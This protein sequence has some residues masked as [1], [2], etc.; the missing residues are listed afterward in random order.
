MLI[1]NE[2]L[3]KTELK[4]LAILLIFQLIFVTTHSQSIGIQFQHNSNWKAILTKAKDENKYILVDCY[5]TWCGP[6]KQMD[7]TVFPLEN[8]G[9]FF[10]E[11]FISVKI[12][13]DSTKNDVEEIKAQ[14]ADAAFIKKEYKITGY[15]T[16]LFFNP[17]G[18]LVHEEGG[19]CSP[20]EFITRGNNA[21]NVESQYYTQ[22]K[23]YNAGD[24]DADFL[25]RLTKLA[26][27]AHNENAISKYAKAYYETQQDLLSSDNLQFVYE[28]TLNANDTG[29]HLM[30]NNLKIFETAVEPK[31]LQTTLKF[32]I[33]RSE[34]RLNNNIGYEWDKKKWDSF[35]NSLLIKYPLF[36]KE[37]LLQFEILVFPGQNNWK[38]YAEAV[39]KYITIQT[40]SNTELNEY[41]WTIFG[42]CNKKAILEKALKWSKMSFT[43]KEKIDPGYIDTYANILYKMG[44]KNEALKWEKKAQKI[45]IEQGL[46]KNW[47]QDVI[48]KINKGE[49]TW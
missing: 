18:E 31:R 17:T 22:I 48:D 33:I 43:N 44:E 14:Y 19:S 40:P 23:K 49:Q 47:G 37:V 20:D 25:K 16:F 5:T 35:A 24:R 8:V 15:P 12:Q 34:F 4:K 1:Y 42:K 29:F 7:A 41:A 45:A 38:G 36:A 11:N 13:F 28:T 10:N 6:C 32:I 26:I 2:K 3:H 46:D 30:S 27:K 9:N 21:L 39:E